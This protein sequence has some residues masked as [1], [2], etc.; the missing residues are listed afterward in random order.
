MHFRAKHELDTRRVLLLLAVLGLAVLVPF[1]GGWGLWY[2]DEPDIGQVARAMY[3]SGDWIAPRRNGEIWIDY[4]PLLYWVGSATA[5][6]LGGLSEFALRLPSALAA[7]ALVLLTAFAAARWHG[8]RAGL[9]SGLV[10]LTFHH[11]AYEAI[12][13]R[14]DVLFALG[15]GGGTIAYALGCDGRGKLGLRVLGFAGLGIAVLAKG[16]LGLLLPGLVL[17]LWHGLRREWKRLLA[18]APLSLVTLGI[19]L[20]WFFACAKEMGSDNILHE[21]YM[22]NFARFKS[23]V[24]YHEKP[25]YYYLKNVWPDLLPWSP[26]LPVAI[27]RYLRGGRWRE[28]HTL[29]G[30]LWFLVTF[31]FLTAAVTKRQLY[32]LPAYPAAALLIGRWIAELPERTEGGAARTP[33]VVRFVTWLMGLGF[34]VGGTVLALAALL[35]D[36]IVAR[37]A[38]LDPLVRDALPGLRL[39]VAIAGLVLLAGGLWILAARRAED[40]RVPLLRVGLVHPVAFVVLLALVLPALDPV[41]SYRK[42]GEWIASEVGG[43]PHFG[44]ADPD[45]G[46]RKMGAFSFY[47]GVLVEHLYSEAEI[48]AYLERNPRSLVLVNVDAIER[49]FT[50]PRADWRWPVVRELHV[51]EY[52]YLALRSP[53]RER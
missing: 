20:P 9:W 7:V 5:H 37:V 43:E 14:P 8:P 4:W 27:V 2:P 40:A 23:G 38:E 39:P 10:L 13:Y 45:Y 32:L 21:I 44:L 12:C 52:D 28:P 25:F 19:A 53:V 15:I 6:L 49:L 31:A 29:L 11:F 48:A 33:R 24:R 26:I 18:L 35:G 1:L 34:V 50:T 22:Q 42:E 46:R 16:P 3:E 47:S 51:A 36:L 17:T 41:R 30:L